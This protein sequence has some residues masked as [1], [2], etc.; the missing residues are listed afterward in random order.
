MAAAAEPRGGRVG[1]GRMKWPLL[2]WFVFAAPFASRADGNL[3]RL[4][5]HVPEE[6]GLV[7]VT[8]SLDKLVGGLAELG[9][10]I[11]YGA[12]GDLNPAKL[13][14]ELDL[15]ERM[16]GVDSSGP[17]LM[18]LTPRRSS[19][20]VIC[21]V[22]DAGIWRAAAGA[23]A[24]EADLW[25]VQLF[26]EPA[27]ASFDGSL[28]ILG[29]EPQTVRAALRGGCDFT[30]RFGP[31]AG[32][33]LADNQL[34]VAVRMP[35][36]T[37]LVTS[38][39]STARAWMQ[40]SMM[41]AGQQDENMVR[42]IDWFFER[43]QTLLDQVDTYTFAGRFG[44]EGV[45]FRDA[46]SFKPDSQVA[47]YLKKVIKTDRNLLRGLL[48]DDDVLVLAYEWELEPGTDS[49]G[50]KVVE[51]LFGS[52]PLRQRLGEE[53]FQPAYQAFV[54]CHNDVS[55]NCTALSA[56]SAEPLL[57][58]SGVQFSSAP[59]QVLNNTSLA[60][61]TIP[62]FFTAFGGGA[63]ADVACGPKRINSIDAFACQLSF[64]AP[65]EQ[66][67]RA[68]E[69]LYG[70]TLTTYYAVQSQ[71]L[72][73]ATGSAERAAAQLARM[74]AGRGRPLAEDP[75]VQQASSRLSPRPQVLFL[76]DG[77]HFLDLVLRIARRNGVGPSALEAPTERW[78]LIA[79][80]GYVDGAALCSELYVPSKPVKAI[81]STVR[82]RRQ[83]LTSAPAHRY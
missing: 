69:Q 25:R 44:A 51:A 81:F 59:Q 23:Q 76:L 60:Y 50:A 17:F 36:W 19:P 55:G 63:T 83:G 75:R 30:A 67:R 46:L 58:F 77:P 3:D 1:N 68:I 42:L 18:A 71:G 40:V 9:R 82:L 24:A 10:S 43:A 61:Q 28:L 79:Y 73:Y 52:G 35:E 37:G 39:L 27:Y 8:P 72:A 53:K 49:L 31:R 7:V 14:S 2:F 70:R 5:A 6:A 80:G 26:G 21:Q 16:D 32:A 4:L 47:A 64:A 74:L 20:L 33:W 57:L 29:D 45:L 38:A 65:D 56:G 41:I 62:E 12:L 15:L 66:T 11:D 48:D 13:V 78:P 34:V 54:A 22:R